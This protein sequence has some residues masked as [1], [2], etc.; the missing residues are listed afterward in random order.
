MGW[1]K[2]MKR[3]MPFPFYWPILLA[4]YGEVFGTDFSGKDLIG[5]ARVST[6]IGCP[7]GI[8]HIDTQLRLCG[9]RHPHPTLLPQHATECGPHTL[10]FSRESLLLK[11]RL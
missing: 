5:L 8:Y 6:G 4:S 1:L 9:S 2:D 10:Y 7:D 11:T 3:I